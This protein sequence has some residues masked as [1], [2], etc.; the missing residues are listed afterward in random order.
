M[1]MRLPQLGLV[2][3]STPI[4]FDRLKLANHPSIMAAGLWR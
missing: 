2:I 3:V 4:P 1:T